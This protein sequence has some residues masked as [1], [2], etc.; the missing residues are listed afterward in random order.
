MSFIVLQPL[1]PARAGPRCPRH[2]ASR[3][4]PAGSLEADEKPPSVAPPFV[5]SSRHRSYRKEAY[6]ARGTFPTSPDGAS[7]A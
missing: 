2:T 7:D 1:L 3:P 6:N 4:A 5:D